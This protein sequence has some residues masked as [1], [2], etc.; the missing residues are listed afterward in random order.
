VWAWGG[1]GH[2]QLGD[3]STKDSNVPVQV[4]GLRGVSSVAAGDRHSLAVNLRV[5]AWGANEHGQL[6]DGSRKDRSVPELV[7]GVESEARGA[8]AGKDYML[9]FPCL[10]ECG[11]AQEQGLVLNTPQ[12]GA[13]PRRSDTRSVMVVAI[14][15]VPIG[16]VVG[17]L[18]HRH[19]RRRRPTHG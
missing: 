14:V 6:G 5:A 9:V 8:V 11:G 1:N 2:G 18:V 16:I 3:G 7:N 10:A 12:T 15:L 4:Q 17:L 19:L 13:K